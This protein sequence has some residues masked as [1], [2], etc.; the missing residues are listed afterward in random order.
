MSKRNFILLI[1]VL[2]LGVLVFFGFLYFKNGGTD[3][4]GSNIPGLNFLAQFN[5]FKSSPPGEGGSTPGDGSTPEDEIPADGEL[6][7]EKLKKVS[8]FPISGFTLF[9]KER[10]K[11]IP[12]PPP[13]PL[14][15]QTEGDTVAHVTPKKI[16]PN[17]VSPPTESALALRYVERS[18]GNI[19]QTFADKIQ[20]RR[21]S[22]TVIPK[23]YDAYFGNQGQSVVMRYLNT[24]NRTIET[25]AGSLPKE[26][27]GEDIES[28]EI[29]G[30]FLPNGI[31]DISLSPDAT[32]IFYLTNISES[33]IGTI[34]NLSD[35]KKIQVFNSAFTE[36]NS[37]WPSNKIITLTTKPSG[38]VPGHM[39]VIDVQKPSEKNFTKVLGD[40]NGLTT[41]MSPNGKL[42]LVGNSALS[43]FVYRMDTKTYEQLG[44]NTLP[45]KC[46]WNSASDTVYCAVP[47]FID[48]ALYPD[49]WYR[50]E[51]SFSDQI[52]KIN[53]QT[54]VASMLIDPIL[55]QDGEDIDGIKLAIDKTENYL[56]FVNKKD[57][58]LWELELN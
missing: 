19:Y 37:F 34:L 33:I 40:I 44:V 57:S 12:I 38:Q 3:G 46:V 47:T 5:P 24:D 16:N 25:F 13:L 14:P 48:A 45:E 10:L 7:I 41:L 56:F 1:I 50:G 4:S 32:K 9:N 55:I 54:G 21:F 2:A 52:W 43:L 27:L 29:K 36:W 22:E 17:P 28:N 8:S 11:E 49:D 35:N 42:V 30:A 39:Y 51:I 18:S 23:I 15:E 31:K 53:V 58:F 6:S 20:E 26:K